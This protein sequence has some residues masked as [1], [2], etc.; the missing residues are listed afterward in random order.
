MC[1]LKVRV[2]VGDVLWCCVLCVVVCHAEKPRVCIRNTLRV[3]VQN[4][5]R[6]YQN[7]AHMYK[8]CGRVAG[9]HGDVLNVHT[10]GLSLSLS[11]SV[12]PPL[13][14]FLLLSSPLSLSLTRG[15]F[16]LPDR[17]VHLQLS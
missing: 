13:L 1:V 16:V 11:P 4:V 6:V 15:R 5:H 8:T 2:R 10:Q 7:H 9:T 14:L 12:P 17:A 3:Y